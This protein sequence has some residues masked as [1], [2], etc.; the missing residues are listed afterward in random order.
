[1]SGQVW[2]EM[3]PIPRVDVLGEIDDA[4][5]YFKARADA[6]GDSEGYYPNEEMTFQAAL[7]DA[8]ARI[9]SAFNALAALE[10]VA[11]SHG[12]PT[13]AARAALARVQP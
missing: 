7:E 5:D 2:Y 6:D 13:D 9:Q 1:M 10:K 3:N 8:H 12:I 11:S 4:I